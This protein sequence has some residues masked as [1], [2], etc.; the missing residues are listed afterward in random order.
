M[1]RLGG[2]QIAKF[3]EAF[4]DRIEARK[5][6]IVLKMRQG[7]EGAAKRKGVTVRWGLK[8][9]QFK[10]AGRRTG[11]RYEVWST[12]DELARDSEVLLLRWGGLYKSGV[13]AGKVLCL[14]LGDL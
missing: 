7:V 8:E 5:D 3:L 12:R 10:T 4:A 1:R 6:E 9:A 14:T 2:E 13:Y 11:T